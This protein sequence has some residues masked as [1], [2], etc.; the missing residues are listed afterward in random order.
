MSVTE[1]F[2]S[3]PAIVQAVK[4]PE[5][6]IALL[7]M[8]VT[9]VVLAMIAGKAKKP[10]WVV[11]GLVLLMIAGVIVLCSMLIVSRPVS[12]VAGTVT[13]DANRQVSVSPQIGRFTAG[14]EAG[15]DSRF[16]VV[17]HPAMPC[18][19]EVNLL[20]SGQAALT[21]P[22]PFPEGGVSMAF[23]VRTRSTNGAADPPVDIQFV[24]ICRHPQ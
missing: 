2:S 11:P 12:V 15:T 10:T 6:L 17:F 16:V 22:K 24:A 20:A 23:D 14:L 19:P 5:G 8:A 13:L 9:M 21:Q 7:I 18:V 3:L 4:T 1:W